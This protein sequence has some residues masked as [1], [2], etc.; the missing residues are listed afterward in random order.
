LPAATEA[1]P[2]TTEIATISEL[3]YEKVHSNP[4]G[5]APEGVKFRLREIVPPG[6]AEPESSASK[7]CCPSRHPGAKEKTISKNL[8][9]CS[10]YLAILFF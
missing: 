2:G 8:T 10:E 9:C 4:A 6:I 1:A 3:E 5:C 7:P